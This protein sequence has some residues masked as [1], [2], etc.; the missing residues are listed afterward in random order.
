MHGRMRLGKQLAEQRGETG[1]VQRMVTE[2]ESLCEAAQEIAVLFENSIDGPW[3]V[4]VSSSDRTRFDAGETSKEFSVVLKN[5]V[6]GF[7][8][9]RCGSSGNLSGGVEFSDREKN[10]TSLLAS[11][12]GQYGF[13]LGEHHRGNGS[14]ATR[15]LHQIFLHR[16]SWSNDVRT[17]G[18]QRGTGFQP[19][20]GERSEA[21]RFVTPGNLPAAKYR[22]P[23][24]GATIG[25]WD[26]KADAAVLLDSTDRLKT[27][28]TF[29]L[30]TCANATTLF[31]TIKSAIRL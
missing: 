31:P 12:M 7:R 19:V 11:K 15:R 30:P 3:H 1:L 28:P 26:G 20:R 13:D 5:V 27:C 22:N 21:E 29:T 16:G 25:A 8:K 14:S 24:A 10:L 4:E 2:G 23:Q 18:R 6:F 9:D 17:A